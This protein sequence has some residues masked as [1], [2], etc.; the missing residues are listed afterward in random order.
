MRAIEDSDEVQIE[1]AVL[2]LSRSQ[3]VCSPLT[4]AVGAFVLL[5]DG[6]R[7]LVSNWRPT[8]LLPL[9][10]HPPSPPS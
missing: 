1:K 2:R 3:R 5:F 8:Q 4:F 10:S 9:P 7:L 6:L